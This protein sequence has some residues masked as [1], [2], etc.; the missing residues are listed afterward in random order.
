MPKTSSSLMMTVRLPSGHSI[1][2]VSLSPLKSRL[3]IGWR[4]HTPGEISPLSKANGD[5]ISRTAA[6]E[7]PSNAPPLS[8]FMSCYHSCFLKTLSHLCWLLV[9]FWVKAPLAWQMLGC[10]F[11]VMQVGALLDQLDCCCSAFL[12]EGQRAAPLIASQYSDSLP[13]P[14]TRSI[15]GHFYA[16]C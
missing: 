16:K 9:F 15:L 8:R 14:C 4:I 13:Q 3:L 2:L 12:L 10:V 11:A 6:P 7:D 1:L 5:V